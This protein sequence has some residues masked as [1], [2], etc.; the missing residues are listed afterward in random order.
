M[1]ALPASILPHRRRGSDG[2]L[3]LHRNLRS[4]AGVAVALL[5][6]MVDMEHAAKGSP[7]EI[8]TDEI[9][10]ALCLDGE[11]E[12]NTIQ[13]V[14]YRHMTPMTDPY[15]DKRRYERALAVLQ[16]MATENTGWRSFFRRWYY[17][18]EPLRNDAANLVR[19][20]GYQHPQPNGTRLVGAPTP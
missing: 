5:H 9:M 6:R 4:R 19:E 20:A 11:D 12:R 16:M 14:L 2:R 17:S 8:L 13:T 3:D 18:D 15:A 1:L 7:V 10:M